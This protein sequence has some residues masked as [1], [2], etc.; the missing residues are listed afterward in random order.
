MGIAPGELLTVYELTQN[1]GAPKQLIEV[2]RP[3]KNPKDRTWR[4]DIHQGRRFG[5]RDWQRFEDAL[6]NAFPE[7]KSEP[8]PTSP[9]LETITV[10]AA[11]HMCPASAGTNG[12]RSIS[13]FS[14]ICCSTPHGSRT[15]DPY[16]D[17]KDIAP[18]R[19]RSPHGSDGR[20]GEPLPSGTAQVRE[21]AERTSLLLV[22]RAWSWSREDRSNGKIRSEPG[23]HLSRDQGVP[24]G[25]REARAGGPL[26]R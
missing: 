6:A 14:P 22:D 20:A 23:S 1:P 4:D 12:S 9:L 26:G 5:E 10:L 24:T 3:L 2:C 21:V 18:P 25:A 19:P 15:T 11:R 17:A 8:Q 13:S 7:H 16:P